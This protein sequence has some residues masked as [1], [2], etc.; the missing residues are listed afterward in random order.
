[1]AR[2][3]YSAAQGGSDITVISNVTWVDAV[4]LAFTPDASASYYLFFSGLVGNSVTSSD[5]QYRVIEG[6]NV[7]ETG[8]LAPKDTSPQ[9]Y[10]PFAG[11]LRHTEGGSPSARSFKIQIKLESSG[12][13]GRIR[14]AKLTAIRH[15]TG[16]LFEETTAAF[17]TGGASGTELETMANASF[18][19][20]DYLVFACARVQAGTANA[21]MEIDLTRPQSGTDQRAYAGVNFSDTT[22]VLHRMLGFHYRAADGAAPGNTIEM[23]VDTPSGTTSVSNRRILALMVTG[24]NVYSNYDVSGSSRGSASYG[25]IST[26]SPTIAVAGDHLVFL[27]MYWDFASSTVSQSVDFTIAGATVSEAVRESTSGVG[28][29]HMMAGVVSLSAGSQTVAARNKNESGTTTF[30]GYE[31][32]FVIWQLAAPKAPPPLRRRTRFFQRRF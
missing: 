18:G 32:S 15:E 28:D 21:L 17:T 2:Q 24:D 4:E 1:M 23:T 26:F 27:L 11:F 14:S 19:A 31:I 9:E 22:S 25:D 13:T 6:A 12:P 29:T 10:Q 16:D 30:N 5:I 20:A 7:L 8:N 3:Y